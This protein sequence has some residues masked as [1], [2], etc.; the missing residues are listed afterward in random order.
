MGVG[1][2]LS[3]FEVVGLRLERVR[4][5]LLE[6]LRNRSLVLGH[7]DVLHAL[8]CKLLDVESLGGCFIPLVVKIHVCQVILNLDPFLFKL[9]QLLQ[10]ALEPL[11][12][13]LQLVLALHEFPDLV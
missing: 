2:D 5:L 4:L 6:V 10:T 3:R 12:K 9:I 11:L 7:G 13:Q 1:D 8:V